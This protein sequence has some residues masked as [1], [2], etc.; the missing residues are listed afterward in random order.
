LL[1]FSNIQYNHVNAKHQFFGFL[2]L[3]QRSFQQGFENTVLINFSFG[4]RSAAV[5][6]CFKLDLC[7]KLSFFLQISIK[8]EINKV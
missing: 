2:K 8:E 5:A 6:R 1:A 7:K 4:L 3:Y